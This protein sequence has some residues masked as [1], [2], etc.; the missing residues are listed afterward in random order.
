MRLMYQLSSRRKIMIN[1][2]VRVVLRMVDESVSGMVYELFPLGM[3]D[4]RIAECAR[5]QQ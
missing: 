3:R 2:L 4:R 1:Q 5:N